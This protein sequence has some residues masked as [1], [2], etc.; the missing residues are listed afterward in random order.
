M[1]HYLLIDGNS[2]GFAAQAMP[3]LVNAGKQTQAIFGF[4]RSL[5]VLCEENPASHPIVFWDGRSWR[6]EHYPEYK[7]GRDKDPKQAA[8][9]EQY[10]RQRPIISRMVAALGVEQRMA[11]NMEADD[12]I[13][14]ACWEL[15]LHDRATVV[16]GDRD[17]LQLVN[18]RVDWYNPIRLPGN[19]TPRFIRVNDESF[20]EDVGYETPVDYVKGKAM[21]GD[22]SDNL[23]GIEGIGEKA[24]PMVVKTW[25]DLSRMIDDIRMRGDA[26]IPDHLSRY[27]KKLKTFAASEEAQRKFLLNFRLMRLTKS[28]IPTPVDLT[29]TRIPFAPVAFKRHCMEQG[30]V[31]ILKD[32]DAWTRPFAEHWEN[33]A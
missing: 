7:A 9:R 31:S 25:P 18:H 3:K 12:L 15:N 30:F 11:A 33:A 10:K 8:E 4:L 23:P 17:L 26:A 2:L 13:A 24:A 6:Y 14:K 29:I 1:T 5:R 32:Y 19:K 28:F 16:S 20:A 22:A 27:K 21:L